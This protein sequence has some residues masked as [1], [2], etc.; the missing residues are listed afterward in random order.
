MK[1]DKS[2]AG[3]TTSQRAKQ[4]IW[5]KT[6]FDASVKDS[7]NYVCLKRLI[8]EQLAT[9]KIIR[10]HAENWKITKQDWR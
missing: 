5:N 7:A 9:I 10:Q 4:S 6:N 1:T 2:V 8:I 3:T